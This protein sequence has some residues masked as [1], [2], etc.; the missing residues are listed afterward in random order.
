MEQPRVRHARA[1]DPI[2]SALLA[3]ELSGKR[4][5]SLAR[6]S[7][8]AFVASVI[9]ACFLTGLA[10]QIVCGVALVAAAALTVTVVRFQRLRRTVQVLVFQ[11]ESQLTELRR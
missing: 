4:L 11:L 5:L 8:A 7:I 10:G 9:A 1:I 6:A 3:A 2:L